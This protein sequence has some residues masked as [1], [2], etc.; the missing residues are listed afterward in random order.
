MSS[1]EVWISDIKLSKLD[2]SDAF[3]PDL[4]FKDLGG[5]V[6]VELAWLAWLGR[7]S[8]WLLFSEL[9]DDDDSEELWYGFPI[10]NSAARLMVGTPGVV[11]RTTLVRGG[12]GRDVSGPLLGLLGLSPVIG[13]CPSTDPGEVIGSCSRSGRSVADIRGADG[14]RGGGAKRSLGR[15]K[16]SER[17]GVAGGSFVFSGA[18]GGGANPPY[19]FFAFGI[20]PLPRPLLIFEAEVLGRSFTSLG[21]L[22][23][24]SPAAVEGRRGGSNGLAVVFM[25]FIRS[26]RFGPCFFGGLAGSAESS[27]PLPSSRPPYPPSLADCGGGG[28]LSAIWTKSSSGLAVLGR[29]FGVCGDML[30]CDPLEPLMGVSVSC[31]WAIN[32]RS[33]P[34]SASKKGKSRHT[35]EHVLAADVST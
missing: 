34:L 16:V 3:L 10:P 25:A 30:L 1:M 18:L 19:P 24:P 13:L 6:L 23:P 2:V 5:L 4:E 33:N 15:G 14:V 9:L 7:R 20:F 28:E 11:G 22:G 27:Y 31:G 32:A 29:S 35:E 17:F 26:I 8:G 12:G 21:P